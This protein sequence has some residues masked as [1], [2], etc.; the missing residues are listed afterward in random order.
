MNARTDPRQHDLAE[1][2]TDAMGATGIEFTVAPIDGPF[3]CSC[4]SRCE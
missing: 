3:D 1:R 2:A 4:R